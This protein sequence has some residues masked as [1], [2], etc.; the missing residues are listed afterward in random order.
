VLGAAD[1]LSV[2]AI[3]SIFVR[4]PDV[5]IG[6]NTGLALWRDGQVHALRMAEGVPFDTVTGIVETAAG[7]LWVNQRSGAVHVTAGEL[8][9]AVA[10]HS[11]AVAAET[12]DRLDGL[13][14]GGPSLF[15][16]PSVIE[17]RDGR[18]WFSTYSGVF[19]LD[20][21]AHYGNAERPVAHITTLELKDRTLQPA[22]GLQ[23]DAGIRQVRFGFTAAS[24]GIP[25]RLRFRYRLSGVDDDWRSSSVRN[26]TYTNLGPGRY[27]FSVM[28][29]NGSGP[30]SSSPATIA[31]SIAPMFWQ[32]MWFRA[33]GIAAFA[34]LLWGLYRWR[35]GLQASRLQV[36]AEARL[37]ERERIARDLHDTLLQG[38]QGLSWKFQGLVTRLPRGDGVRAEM[39]DALDAADLLI[40]EGRDSVEGLRA[41][42]EGT[43]LAAAIVAYVGQLAV[44][45]P[46]S[47]SC[48][49]E[50]KPR[51]LRD[52]AWQELFRI[53]CEACS[54]A[55]RHAQATTVRVSVRYGEG[56]LSV[57]INDD[58]IGFVPPA[59]TTGD[60][61]R[62]WGLL[63]MRERAA[64]LGG[65][66]RV[67]SAPGRGTTIRL[68]IA[69]STAYAKPQTGRFGRR[70]VGS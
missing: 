46:T 9:R 57:E 38:V 15:P 21:R 64:R 40:A 45:S 20:P 60:P 5:W 17:G 7:E 2:G 25:E 43:E 31:F 34:C 22:D 48:A 56:G 29:A 1:G 35:L 68:E 23:L 69:A 44:A 33:L 4:G 37:A 39:E 18:L 12:F 62:R 47:L 61:A 28:A 36:S 63:G 16:T 52:D 70:A 10:D 26:T 66:L 32:T 13:F 51:A 59:P 54:N 50:Q 8:R 49:V 55:L 67:D 41:P 30:W 42:R 27:T 24:L 14:G 53:G 65:T 58:G 19:W 6:G 3:R 11:Y